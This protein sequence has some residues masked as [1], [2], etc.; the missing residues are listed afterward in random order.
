M[1]FVNIIGNVEK[2]RTEAEISA[3]EETPLAVVYE[4][5]AGWHTDMLVE[6][7][8]Q[9]ANDFQTAI[10]NAKE[11]LSHYVN[12][13]GEDPPENASWGALSLWLMVKDDGTAMGMNMKSGQKAD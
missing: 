4:T 3:S 12:R 7:L 1:Y 6:Q 9:A 2:C 10:E 11:R 13:R 8:N 5:S